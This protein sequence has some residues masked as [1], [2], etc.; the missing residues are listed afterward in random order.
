MINLTNS[1]IKNIESF[2]AWE[3]LKS[4][5]N[6]HLIDVRTIAEWSFVGHPD[7]QPINKKPIF[8]S[9]K[10]YPDMKTNENFISHL[11]KEITDKESKLFFICKVGGRSMSAAKAAY[12]AG[13]VNSYNIKDGFDGDLDQ[14]NQRGNIN[15]WRAQ[16]LFWRQD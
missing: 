14:N 11:E 15:G 5:K 1:Y 12:D 4:E 10:L 16:K 3:V 9:W 8:L 2:E 7:L 13:F 6:S